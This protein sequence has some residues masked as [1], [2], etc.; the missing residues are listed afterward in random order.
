MQYSL[1]WQRLKRSTISDDRPLNNLWK[2]TIQLGSL[3][4]STEYLW[5]RQVSVPSGAKLHVSRTYITATQYIYT[6]PKWPIFWRWVLPFVPQSGKSLF[7]LKDTWGIRPN[8]V[9]WIV[10][11][12]SQT[13][14]SSFMFPVQRWKGA[15]MGPLHARFWDLLQFLLA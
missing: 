13:F 14:P 7:K 3:L 6:E 5:P 11:G 9:M 4:L 10:L 2:R 8:I 15:H 12:S 1:F